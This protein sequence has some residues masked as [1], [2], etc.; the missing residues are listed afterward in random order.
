MKDVFTSGEVAKQLGCS[1]TKINQLID[2]EILKGYRITKH[3]R[4]RREDLIAY[5]EANGIPLGELMG[6]AAGR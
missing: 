6:S 5:M 4:V 1:V 3:R 2:A